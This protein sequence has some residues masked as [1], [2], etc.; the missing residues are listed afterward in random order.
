MKKREGWRLRLA[1]WIVG[2]LAPKYHLALNPPKGKRVTAAV[3]F[4]QP[5][6]SG[7]DE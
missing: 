4:P 7:T 3:N 2:I 5:G 1:A 6:V